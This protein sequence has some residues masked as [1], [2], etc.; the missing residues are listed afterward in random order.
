[1]LRL[2][3]AIIVAFG[4]SSTALAANLTVKTSPV[5]GGGNVTPMTTAEM[6]QTTA[7]GVG[8]TSNYYGYYGYE[9][10]YKAYYYG[11]YGNYYDTQTGGQATPNA[12][13]YYDYAQQWANAA[14]NNYIY[15]YEYAIRGQ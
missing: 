6:G 3:L 11:W 2:I 7:K 10:A 12:V 14:Y 5:F 8:G 15:A 1:M 13:A 9:A 4:F